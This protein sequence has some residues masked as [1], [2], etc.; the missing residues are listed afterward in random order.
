MPRFT[1]SI[2]VYNR[3]ELTRTCI[4]S[5]LHSGGDFE[6]I[7]TDN[8]S[9][10]DTR[11][12][13]RSLDP[14][15]FRI[16]TNR[17][18]LGFNGPHN[19]ALTLARGEFFVVLNNDLEVTAGWLDIMAAKFAQNPNLAI[20]GVHGGC[21]RIDKDAVG[22]DDRELEYV[23]GSCL[24]IPTVLARRHGLFAN[25]LKFAYFEDSDLSLRM[26]EMG[27]DIA[28]ADLHFKH[29]RRSTALLVRSE[30][31]IDLDAICRR[32][33][34]AF[35]MKWKRYLEKRTFAYR[36][37]VRRQ[38]SIGDVLLTTPILRILKKKARNVEITVHTLFP[39][40]FRGNPNVSHASKDLPFPDS[41]YDEKY[42]LDL[43]YERFPFMPIVAAYAKACGI[44]VD[45]SIPDLYSIPEEEAWAEN[46]TPKG[47][48]LALHPGPTAWEGRNWPL[49]RFAAV[50]RYFQ[51]K[52]W[53]AVVVGHPGPSLPCDFDFRGK[54][55]LHSLA[56]VLRRCS[57]FVGIDSYPMHVAVSVNIPIVATF[58]CILPD[59]RLPGTGYFLSAQVQGLSCLGCHHHQPPPVTS[60]KCRFGNP[61]CMTELSVD[62][63]IEMAEMAFRRYLELGGSPRV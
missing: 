28:I 12:Y 14:S 52:G 17:E 2:A 37:L 38:A 10:E 27:H 20:C 36:I 29:N 31:K 6:V 39:E 26:R 4:D 15:R 22:V 45:N 43:A 24:M 8:A 55:T 49:E 21:T 18:N 48:V 16:V 63:V 9:A 11:D 59:L 5:I 7:V 53:K 62:H 51:A 46:Y 19:H 54:T 30:G 47:R 44:P 61:R 34:C 33:R 3:L 41:N 60:S 40:I 50:A 57:L 23:E 25:Y 32:N 13:L 56:S 42:D 1:V 58:G 35:R